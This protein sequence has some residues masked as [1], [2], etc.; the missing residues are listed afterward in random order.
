MLVGLGVAQTFG[1]GA[2]ALG[3]LALSAGASVIFTAALR[4]WLGAASV[5]VLSLPFACAFQ[6]A[7]GAAV[8]LGLPALPHHADAG[9]LATA[10]PAALALFLRSLGGLFFLPR[11]D[12]GALVLLALMVHSRIALSLAASAFGAA[13]A[14]AASAPLLPEGAGVEVLASNAMLTAITLGGVFFVPSAS[15]FALAL[16]G[17]CVS[18]LL[19]LGLAAPFARLGVPL[20]IVPFNATVIVTLLALRQRRRDVAPKSVDFLSGTPEENLAYFRTRRARFEQLHP[21]AF[22][23]PVRGT[24]TCTQG[25]D[26]PFTHQGAWRHAFDL[27]VKDEGA[28]FHR[29][30]G[31]VNED[32]HGFRLPVLAAAPG[33]VVA[34]EASVPDNAVGAVDVEHNWGNH[35]VIQHGVGLFSLVAHLAR[36]S[37][38]VRVGH[39]VQRG[40][41]VGLVGSSGRSPRPHLHFHLQASAA[42]GAPTLPCAFTDVVRVEAGGEHR[43]YASLVPRVGDAVRSILAGDEIAGY[44]ALEVGRCWSFWIGQRVERVACELDLFGRQVLRSLDRPAT[45]FFGL[46]EGSFRAFD[47]VGD[48]ASALHLVRAAL[49]LLPLEANDELVF[50]D[51]LPARPFRALVLRVLFDALS[52]FFARD[53]IAMELRARRE[54]ERLVVE[55]RSVARDRAGVPIVQTRAELA[56][57]AGL[58]RVVVTVRGRSMSAERVADASS[59]RRAR[60]PSLARPAAQQSFMA[61]HTATASID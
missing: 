25:V 48:R 46:G 29:G 16:T 40:E 58:E 1:L 19:S 51:H 32:F 21:V 28:S 41:V 7:L 15:S 2:L 60:P 4:A 37:A 12:A 33:T 49:P 57:G 59:P 11:T 17:A 47:A 18:M 22:T 20:F 36:G 53:D 43:V 26:G 30:A 35:V 27:E 3:L 9:L 13:V 42:L 24:W 44:L 39:V 10:L 23:L 6:L 31:L 5:P 61:V 52:P 38:K 8:L 54:G 14:V 45:L 50:S 55:G 34:V 56:R